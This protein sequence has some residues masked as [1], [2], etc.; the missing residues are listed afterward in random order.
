MTFPLHARRAVACVYIVWFTISLL[1][2]AESYIYGGDYIAVT[3]TGTL[4]WIGCGS[5]HLRIVKADKWPRSST[6]TLFFPSDGF[7]D[8]PYV[9]AL[10]LD[11]SLQPSVWTKYEDDFLFNITYGSVVAE[12][13]ADGEPIWLDPAMDLDLFSHKSTP[14]YSGPMRF[15]DVHVSLPTVVIVSGFPYGMMAIGRSY[16]SLCRALRRKHGRCVRCGYDV[17]ESGG[18][19]SECGTLIA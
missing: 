10:P 5:G 18:R 8:R 11:P 15:F 6:P 16:R 14:N 3:P 13:G 17:R 12:L 19:C 2:L 7:T 1:L 4:W 9:T